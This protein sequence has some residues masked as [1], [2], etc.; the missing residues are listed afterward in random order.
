MFS[1]QRRITKEWTIVPGP[2]EASSGRDI[3]SRDRVREE[4]RVEAGSNS[5][6]V[7]LRVV[8]GDEKRNLEFETVKY[9]HESNGTRT[10]E[11]LAGEG[12]QQL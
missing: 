5:S 7:S 8:G 1:W 2:R 9:D 12:Q 6:T 4:Y 3:E 10:R 11:W